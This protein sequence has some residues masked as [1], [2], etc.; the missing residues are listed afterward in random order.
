MRTIRRSH[1]IGYCQASVT[2]EMYFRSD[3][4]TK[5]EMCPMTTILRLA[6]ASLRNRSAAGIDQNGALLLSRIN[7]DAIRM[8]FWLHPVLERR[9]RSDR[10]Y[11]R[12][13][14]HS[15]YQAYGQG[16]ED[17][18]NPVLAPEL[19]LDQLRLAIVDNGE[20]QSL[21]PLAAA[22]FRPSPPHPTL[23][24]TS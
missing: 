1:V 10:L 21:G 11:R 20:R 4:P 9:N 18:G 13:Q 23:A 8:N 5:S 22:V 12:H 24:R 2:T 17:A 16:R 7:V 6:L 14:G 15:H 3:L 19:C